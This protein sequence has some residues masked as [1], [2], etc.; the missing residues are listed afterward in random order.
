MLTG[1]LSLHLMAALSRR[2]DLAIDWTFVL[3]TY[4]ICCA[5]PAHAF[6]VLLFLLRFRTK[7]FQFYPNRHKALLFT[8]R[9]EAIQ[10]HLVRFYSDAV[11][12]V[13]NFYSF[14]LTVQFLT[15]LI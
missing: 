10:S 14:E 11:N 4:V 2:S 6:I 1:F 3:D 9:V 12:L 15:V 13:P 7:F 5:L 8:G